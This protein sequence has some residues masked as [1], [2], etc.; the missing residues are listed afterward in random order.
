MTDAARLPQWAD[1]GVPA[2][3]LDPQGISRRGLLQQAG[4]YGT[5]FA[6]AAAT[7]TLAAPAAAASSNDDP[8]LVYLVGDHHVHT[9]FSHDAKYRMPDLARRGAQFG[10]DWMVFTEHSNFGH[11]DFG[12]AQENEQI[13]LARAENPRLLIFQGLE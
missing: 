11:A 12:A 7:D 2:A 6:A 10:L 8:D 4:L 5:G 9:V 13:R 3:D 1:P